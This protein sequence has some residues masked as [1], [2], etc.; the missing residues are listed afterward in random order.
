MTIYPWM[1]L[2]RKQTFTQGQG[3]SR[4]TKIL[5]LQWLQMECVR[6]VRTLSNIRHWNKWQVLGL[7]S[8]KSCNFQVLLPLESKMTHRDNWASA[9]QDGF[10]FFQKDWAGFWKIFPTLDL[11][12]SMDGDGVKRLSPVEMC[13]DDDDDDASGCET[14]DDVGR[15]STNVRP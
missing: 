14:F 10:Y 2:W 6:H 1:C 11:T 8:V 3:A 4:V 9:Q 7:D 13:D 15:C 5:R 12:S